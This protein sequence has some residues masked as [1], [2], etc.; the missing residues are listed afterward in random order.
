MLIASKIFHVTL[1][2]LNYFCEQFAA[3]EIRHSRCDC[4]VCQQSTWYLL[5]SDEDSILIKKVVFKE[6]HS[7]EVD[8]RIS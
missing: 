7:K 6:T 8:R 1:L 3:P 2:L 5:L 4:S